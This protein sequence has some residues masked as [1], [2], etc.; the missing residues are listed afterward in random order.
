MGENALAIEEPARQDLEEGHLCRGQTTKPR[1]N[2]GPGAI[3]V[4]GHGF[5]EA[6]AGQLRD[7]AGPN[8]FRSGL[9]GQDEAAG[10][11]VGPGGQA[12]RHVSH[13]SFGH[14]DLA[15]VVVWGVIV[16]G[17]RARVPGRRLVAQADGHLFG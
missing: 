16:C 7:P 14:G 3:R 12:A 6:E 5:R 11:P 9:Q 15:R 13:R 8:P 10:D 1:R 4:D 17:D 2:T